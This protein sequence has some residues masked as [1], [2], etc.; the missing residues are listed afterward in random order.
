[1]LGLDVDLSA[2]NVVKDDLLKELE[3]MSNRYAVMKLEMTQAK[4]DKGKSLLL[5]WLKLT[6]L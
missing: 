3:E 4:R 5:L 1:M 2:L 6:L